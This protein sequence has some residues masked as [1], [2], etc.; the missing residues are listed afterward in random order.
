MTTLIEK[1]L[2]VYFLLSG[3]TEVGTAIP[4]KKKEKQRK[5]WMKD[6][7]TML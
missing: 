1:A 6:T 4:N 3:S 7:F 5:V 2:T